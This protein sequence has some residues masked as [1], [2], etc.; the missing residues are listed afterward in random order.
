MLCKERKQF[1]KTRLIWPLTSSLIIN[2]CFT[3]CVE[4]MPKC[5]KFNNCILQGIGKLKEDISL[6]QC[7]FEKIVKR[8]V[9]MHAYHAVSWF[10]YKDLVH[11]LTLKMKRLFIK[12]GSYYWIKPWFLKKKCDW[13]VKLFVWRHD[14]KNC[15]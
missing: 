6:N 14:E 10:I 12:V 8:L 2:D 1:F 5:W 3:L 13:I 15:H 11:V 7:N 4:R 9:S